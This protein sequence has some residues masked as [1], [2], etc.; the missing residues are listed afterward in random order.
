MADHRLAVRLDLTPVQQ[1]WP[2]H[3]AQFGTLG[4]H[5]HSQKVIGDYIYVGLEFG[6]SKYLLGRYDWIPIGQMYPDMF[7]F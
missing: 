6:G 3:L 5:V 4:I 7:D 1:F 2:F